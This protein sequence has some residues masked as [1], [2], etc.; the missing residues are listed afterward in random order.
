[1]EQ[2][3]E[4]FRLSVNELKSKTFK[5]SNHVNHEV[6]REKKSKTF[7]KDGHI[8]LKLAKIYLERKNY[9]TKASDHGD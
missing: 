5:G 9:K 7:K 3:R 1:M 4:P 6:L 8:P 2:P